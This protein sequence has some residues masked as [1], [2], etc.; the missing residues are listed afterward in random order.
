MSFD[1]GLAA[2]PKTGLGIAI[3]LVEGHSPKGQG[4]VQPCFRVDNHAEGRCP[5]TNAGLELTGTLYRII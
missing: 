1:I 2:H 4:I 3:A 5:T